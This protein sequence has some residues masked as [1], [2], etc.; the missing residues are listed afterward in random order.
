MIYL[1]LLSKIIFIIFI[2]FL[3]SGI[4]SDSVVPLNDLSNEYLNEANCNK[5]NIFNYFWTLSGNGRNASVSHIFGTLKSLT[6]NEEL[7][8]ELW[9]ELNNSEIILL[10]TNYNA[11]Q[12]AWKECFK[13][14]K[15][16]EIP[17]GKK[18]EEKLQNYYNNHQR[19]GL[20]NY[21]NW[22][23]LPAQWLF[24]GLV[25]LR[26]ELE[27][28]ATNNEFKNKKIT[29]EIEE[30]GN[31]YQKTII[32]LTNL[33]NDLCDYYPSL[34]ADGN[35]MEFVLDKLLKEIEEITNK[36]I[37]GGS[38]QRAI[39]KY[40]C[41]EFER[42]DDLIG[43]ENIL[44][45][46][47]DQIDLDNFRRTINLLNKDLAKHRQRI[48]T[49]IVK[50]LEENPGKKLFVV[51]SAGHLVGDDSLIKILAEQGFNLKQYSPSENPSEILQNS[52]EFT[53]KEEENNEFLL[54]PTTNKIPNIVFAAALQ[55]NPPSFYENRSIREEKNRENEENKN[56][57]EDKLIELN[58]G[59]DGDL[60]LTTTKIMP[61]IKN[62][63]TEEF[64]KNF[65]FIYSNRHSKASYFWI[66]F[67][68]ILSIILIILILCWYIYN[69]HSGYLKPPHLPFIN[70]K[71]NCCQQQSS[72]IS[73]AKGLP[74]LKNNSQQQQ[75]W[76]T[77]P[78]TPKPTISS[79]QYSQQQ[80]NIFPLNTS[81]PKSAT[82]FSEA[83]NATGETSFNICENEGGGNIKNEEEEIKNN[84]SFENKN[85]NSS[86]LN[87]TITA[88]PLV[89]GQYRSTSSLALS[90]TPKTQLNQSR[91]EI[92]DKNQKIP[93][94]PLKS[95]PFP[96]PPLHNNIQHSQQF[97]N[98]KD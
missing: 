6:I 50:Y 51:V 30:I 88:T 4:Q 74:E 45:E 47:F 54:K 89:D 21:F 11:K 97:Q 14:L 82:S 8:K 27:K 49:K 1:Q 83:S 26:A 72:N 53:S 25:D 10:E 71:T 78:T 58:N 43:E 80:Q 73:V 5:N 86:P 57:D 40:K 36:K 96:P 38:W 55:G 35:V 64:N 98:Q 67:T 13:K 94:E 41:G 93:Q 42:T 28:R 66:Y 56:L 20:L 65:T 92:N 90:H 46:F 22:K 18:I 76:S 75:I 84:A 85:E 39:K 19:F 7:P 52:P 34:A 87:P 81:P 95:P 31:K 91:M 44:N 12:A 48:A 16:K 32:Y 59:E 17:F 62:N 70:D 69:K 3:T 23:D 15:E 60:L 2:I 33:T 9:K 61:L 37:I 29:K 68:S 77:T 63:M 79:P 24:Q